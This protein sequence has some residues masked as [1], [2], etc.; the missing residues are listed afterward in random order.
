MHNKQLLSLAILAALGI[1]TTGC[2]SDD[3]DNQVNAPRVELRVLE[4]SDIHTNIMDFDYFKSKEDPTI[5]LAR[6]ASAI[7]AARKEAINHVLVDNGD[8][9]QGSPMGDYMAKLTL[10]DWNTHPAYKAMNTL[11]YVVGNIGNHEFNYGLKFLQQ[12]VAGA[13]FPYISANVLCQVDDC[14][15]GIDKDQPIF[16]PYLIVEKQ[17]LDKDGNEHTLKIGYIGFV[18]PQIEQWDRAHLNGKVY[19][20][21]IIEAAEKYVPQMKSEGADVIIA[22]PHSGIGSTTAPGDA[23]A[24]NATF[25]LTEVDGIDAIMFGHSHA[26][27][28]HASYADLPNTD[29]EKGLLNGV[30]SVMPGRW[31][32][33]LGVVDLVLERQNDSWQVV[34][35]RAESRPIYDG[36]NKEPLVEADL[37][38]RQEVEIEH[39]GTLAFVDEK[40]GTASNDMYSFLTLVQD[41]PSVQIVSNAQIAKVSQAIA[42][43][44]AEDQAKF[45]GMPVLSAA[46]PFKAGGRHSVEA[47]AS[48]YVQVD[49]GELKFKHAADLY[50]Y[51]NTL[52]AVKVSGA[53]LK[54]WLEC[55][56]NQFTQIDPTSTEPQSLIN[57]G[58]PTYNFD[59]IDGVS[60]KIDVTQPSKFDRDCAV[61]NA[62]ANRIVE[63]SYTD[64]E[65][66]VVTGAELAKM[67]FIVATNNYRAYGGKFAGTGPE[68]VVMELPDANRE[69]LAAYITSETNANGVVDPTAD[70]NWDFKDIEASGL[71]VRF[72]T[73]DSQKAADF[74]SATAQRKMTKVGTDAIGFAVY[75]VELNAPAN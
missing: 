7:H 58:H 36:A 47:D 14:W 71:D 75:K 39:L 15:P 46:A 49:K 6:T 9:L 67:N 62:D 37:T 35:S 45:A 51:P 54:D 65:G 12:A 63:L 40:I 3:N 25:A 21:G 38:I 68:H 13:N 26:I 28:P 27:F 44:S 70:Y 42:D 31:G 55:S 10:D 53:E 29:I 16:K 73:Q 4:T 30:P 50:L 20:I 43:M 48:Q 33:N 72:E 23:R 22:I 57:W 1:S 66:K 8:L 56:A 52:M 11:D 34:D 5:G 32:D 61:V 60:Y 2:N 59:V 74:I 69:A 64:A 41:D 19:A 18:P 17:V 24:E